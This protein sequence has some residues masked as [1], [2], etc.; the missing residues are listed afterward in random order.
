MDETVVFSVFVVSGVVVTTVVSS[1]VTG[2]VPVV[3]VSEV[4]TTVVV[5]SLEVEGAI[6]NEKRKIMSDLIQQK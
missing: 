6:I 4:V 5:T 1:V 2:V 3:G